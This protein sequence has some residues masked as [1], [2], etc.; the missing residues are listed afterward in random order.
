MN[1]SCNLSYDTTEIDFS[2]LAIKLIPPHIAFQNT[3]PYN[4]T[5]DFGVGSLPTTT[6]QGIGTNNTDTTNFLFGGGAVSLS[7]TSEIIRGSIEV[8]GILYYSGTLQDEI[9][10]YFGSVSLIT[11]TNKNPN[12][13]TKIKIEGSLTGLGVGLFNNTT[14]SGSLFGE[15]IVSIKCGIRKISFPNGSISLVL[16]IP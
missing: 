12:N 2:N 1:N 9:S 4:V 14:L 11:S 6:Y 10:R 16:G 3:L 13:Q 7:T 5:I 15:G 8:K